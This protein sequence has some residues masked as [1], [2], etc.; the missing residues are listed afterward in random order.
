MDKEKFNSSGYIDMTAYVAVQNVRREERRKLIA[1]IKAL[2]NK[3]GY[4]VT[5]TITLKE[6]SDDGK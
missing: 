2:A 4:T 1:K 6:I 3:Y 5:G